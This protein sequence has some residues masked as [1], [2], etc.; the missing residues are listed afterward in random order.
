M[1]NGITKSGFGYSIDTQALNDW[2]LLELIDEIDGKPTAMIRV[3]KKL[4]GEE[5]Y[6]SLKSHC[7]VDGKVLLDMMMTEITEI[8]NSNSVKNS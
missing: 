8:L 2:E 1:I 6:T 3:A 4:L 7:T 5:I